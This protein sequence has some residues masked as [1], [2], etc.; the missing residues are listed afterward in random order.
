MSNQTETL[1]HMAW[2][3]PM[4]FMF[5]NSFG[6]CCRTP[7]I[8]IDP[9]DLNL[10]G[11]DYFSN[12]PRFVERRKALLNGIKHPDCNTCWQLED[13]GFKSSRSDGEFKIFMA[14]NNELIKKNSSLPFSEYKKVPDLEKSNYSNVIEIVLNNTCD[15]KCTYCSEFYSTQWLTEKKKYKEVSLKYVP[16]D[17]RNPKAEELF[18]SW[19]K[20]R[21][22]STNRRFG[23]I[24]GEPFIIEELY[25]CFDK[26]IEIHSRA[27]I[28]PDP[29]LGKMEL[30]ITSNLNTPPAYFEKFLNYIPKL[31]KYFKIV[32][33]VSGENTGSD[34][35]YIRYGVKWDRWSNNVE[36]LLK[37]TNVTLAFLPCLSLL[38][39]PRFYLYLEYF[40]GLCEKYRFMNIH[41]NIVTHP[42]EQSPM[43]AP[44]EF[45]GYFDKCIEI[46][47]E[48][49]KKYTKEDATRY[50]YRVF[51]QW[52]HS[53]K[54]SITKNQEETES[55][56][57]ALKFYNF[58]SRLDSRRNTNVLKVFPEFEKFYLAGQQGQ[59]NK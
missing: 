51:L 17:N 26:L 47:E 3:Y 11:E 39:I 43:I 36:H 8:G 20:N 52:L 33:Q 25:E 1:C 29:V 55:T 19:Y 30:C 53:V 41:H 35:E 10:M 27:N 38:T 46:I 54:E 15:A 18:W 56:S 31:E 12:H 22:I 50:S 5:T 37:H 21:A 6:Y 40:V 4:F 42:I 16:Q 2:D 59:Q 28:E 34:L 9:T 24:G 14:K 7:R 23:F 32:I 48:L 57:N 49:M 58:V 13:A 44:K 45:A